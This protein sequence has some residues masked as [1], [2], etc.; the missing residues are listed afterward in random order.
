MFIEHT[1][2]HG[3]IARKEQESVRRHIANEAFRKRCARDDASSP[4]LGGTIAL[5]KISSEDCNTD[6]ETIE[7]TDRDKVEESKPPLDRL[8]VVSLPIGTSDD[9]ELMDHIAKRLWPG[10]RYR[11]EGSVNPFPAYWLPRSLDN[12]ALYYA[13]AFSALCHLSSRLSLAGQRPR[14]KGELVSLETRALV[15]TR[16]QI[17]FPTMTEATNALEDLIMITICLATN[18]QGESLMTTRDPSPFYPILTSGR[19]LDTYGALA[20]RNIHWNAVQKL[21][22]K[23]GGIESITSFGLPWVITW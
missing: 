7:K 2:N 6:R 10:F 3:G 13:L 1:G 14:N 15:A 20:G 11:F 18:V 4:E 21:I 5:L 22:E 8:S 9:T 12:P 19:W 23:R 16:E 17:S